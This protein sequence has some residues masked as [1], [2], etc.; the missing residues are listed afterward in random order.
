VPELGWAIPF[1]PWRDIRVP[2]K[3]F[4]ILVRFIW[5][6]KRLWIID[7]WHVKDVLPTWVKGSAGRRHQPQEGERIEDTQYPWLGCK[8]NLHLKSEA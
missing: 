6:V 4:L 5:T 1:P 2:E 8:C 7:S 3:A